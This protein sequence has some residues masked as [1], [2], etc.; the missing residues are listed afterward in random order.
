VIN[1]YQVKLEIYT[2]MYVDL[3]VQCSLSLSCFNQNSNVLIS[4]IFDR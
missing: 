3:L 2:E 4:R 1:V